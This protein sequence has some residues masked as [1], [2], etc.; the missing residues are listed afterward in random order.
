MALAAGMAAALSPTAIPVADAQET[1][2]VEV[3]Q[4]RDLPIRGASSGSVVAQHGE[5]ESKRGPVGDPP[6]S[7]WYY[8]SFRVYFEHN[9]VITTVAEEDH[10]PSKLEA[11]Q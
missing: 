8:P 10:L 7:T 4:A 9:L 6:I 2:F 1:A 3:E 5:P 11:I